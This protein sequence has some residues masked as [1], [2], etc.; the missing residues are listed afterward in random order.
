MADDVARDRARSL[1]RFE[2]PELDLVGAGL[3]ATIR[4]LPLLELE[5]C[6]P[7]AVLARW[8]SGG[9]DPRPRRRWA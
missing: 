2:D 1:A 4:L 8:K 5:E 6:T 9:R 3:P 7:D